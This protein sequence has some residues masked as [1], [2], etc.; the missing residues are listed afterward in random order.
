MLWVSCDILEVAAFRE[1]FKTSVPTSEFVDLSRVPS[2]DLMDNC[3]SILAHHKAPCVFLGFLEPGW[4]L[5][6][7]HQTR[8]RSLVRAR[9]VAFVCHFPESIPFSL[10]NEIEFLYLSKPNNGGAAPVDDGRAL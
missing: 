9:P 2:A 3:E 6:P 5:D 8:I 7:A 1:S 4:M 10:K